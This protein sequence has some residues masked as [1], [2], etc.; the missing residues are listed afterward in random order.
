MKSFGEL[1]KAHRLANK[2]TLREISKFLGLSIGYISDIEHNRKS[3]P[4]LEIVRKYEEKTK[5][6]DNSL[7]ILASQLKKKLPNELTQR[8]QLRPQLSDML[9]RA[10]ELSDNDLEDIKGLIEHKIR[11]A[12]Q[13]D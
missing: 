12:Q 3:P 9:Y 1:W 4:D 8:I 6:K 7:V 10:D 2:F 5:V 13:K 11:S